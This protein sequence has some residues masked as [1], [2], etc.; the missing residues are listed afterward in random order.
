MRPNSFVLLAL[1]MATGSAVGCGDRAIEEKI[2]LVDSTAGPTGGALFSPSQCPKYPQSTE[3]DHVCMIDGTGR[4]YPED[5]T[6]FVFPAAPPYGAFLEFNDGFVPLPADITTTGNGASVGTFAAPYA[7][8]N[9]PCCAEANAA[10]RV[11]A[12]ARLASTHGLLIT[13][14]DAVP[15]GSQIA[16]VLDYGALFASQLM[17]CTLANRDFCQW[18]PNSGFAMRFY[19]GAL[20]PGATPPPP[21]LDPS[22][23]PDGACLLSYNTA[24]AGGDPCC[25]RKGGRNTC[26]RAIACNAQ[27]GAGCCRIYASENTV[28][29]DRCCLYEDGSAGSGAAECTQLLSASR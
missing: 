4:T 26:N 12:T 23:V 7:V 2:P 11:A 16:I 17:P 8:N 21:P 14:P 1:A 18:A 29:G 20:P 24:L 27:S 15:V 10:N 5:G 19:V 9:N 6:L 28:G 13:I 25:Y 22:T 3:L